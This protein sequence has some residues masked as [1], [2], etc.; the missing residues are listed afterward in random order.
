MN[1]FVETRNS[2]VN[3]QDQHH[4]LAE[5]RSFIKPFNDA[6]YECAYQNF[7]LLII[8]YYLLFSRKEIR[9][10]TNCF[11]VN[12]A[13]ADL[14]FVMIIPAIAGARGAPSWNLGAFTCKLLPYSQVSF[15]KLQSIYGEKE[16]KVGD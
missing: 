2:F 9:T 4:H 5:M 1:Q 15:S 11:I 7:A 6:H 13:C 12:L 14:V 3:H 8:I 10:V 16:Q